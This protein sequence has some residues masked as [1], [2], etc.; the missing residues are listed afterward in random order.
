MEQKLI[1][2]RSFNISDENYRKVCIK[3]AEEQ[4]E[5]WKVIDKILKEHFDKSDRR[6]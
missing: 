1:T 6:D 3:A 5:K 4:T 2:R